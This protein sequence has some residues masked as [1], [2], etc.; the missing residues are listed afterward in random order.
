[1]LLTIAVVGAVVGIGTS[2]A[3]GV[4]A[5]WPI[6]IDLGAVLLAVGFAAVVGAVFGYY[7]AR[8]AAHLE[9]IEAL[10]TE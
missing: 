10:S 2:I 1:M 5:E 3:I 8:R 9:P 6:V 4:L 7:P